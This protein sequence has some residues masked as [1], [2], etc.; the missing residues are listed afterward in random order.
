MSEHSTENAKSNNVDRGDYQ[1]LKC[2]V[3]MQDCG[4]APPKTSIDVEAGN[5]QVMYSV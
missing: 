3:E 2:V 4:D 1:G 5:R